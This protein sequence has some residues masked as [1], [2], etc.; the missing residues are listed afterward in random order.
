MNV[1]CKRYGDSAREEEAKRCVLFQWLSRIL[2]WEDV[3]AELL[4]EGAETE[5]C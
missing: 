4:C 2:P 1:L 5:P 3:A